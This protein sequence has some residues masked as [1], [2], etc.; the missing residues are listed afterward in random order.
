MFCAPICVH[1]GFLSRAPPA[2]T[3]LEFHFHGGRRAS[4]RGGPRRFLRVKS[5][6]EDLS[7]GGGGGGTHRNYNLEGMSWIIF[8][9]RGCSSKKALWNI[10][11]GGRYRIVFRRRGDRYD[12]AIGSSSAIR[13]CRLVLCL[14]PLL[15]WMVGFLTCAAPLSSGGGGVFGTRLCIPDYVVN[16]FRPHSRSF[17]EEAEE[18]RGGG[19]YSF[20][21]MAVG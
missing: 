9:S 15:L 13:P 3:F 11:R 12:A 2:V 1:I 6:G 21:G 16:R 14:A 10:S 18:D 8:L 19:V 20:S 4:G 7:G 17:L 5:L